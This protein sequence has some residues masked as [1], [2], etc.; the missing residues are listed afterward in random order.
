MKN[1]KITGRDVVIGLIILV[2]F[3]VIGEILFSN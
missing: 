1:N 3:V 2:S